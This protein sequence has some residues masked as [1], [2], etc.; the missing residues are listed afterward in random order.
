[1]IKKAKA[2][3]KY[4]VATGIICYFLVAVSVS[5]LTNGTC[6][7]GDSVY[8]YLFSHY[9][10][11]HPHNF[12]DHWAKPFFVLLSSPFAQF[13]FTGIKLFNCS[14]AAVSLW[15]C[16]KAAKALGYKNAWLAPVFLGFAPGWF[17]HLFSGLTEPLFGLLLITGVYLA[18][19]K[20]DVWA[21]IVISF[22]PFVRSEGLIIMVVFAFYFLVN[23]QY[24]YILWLLTGHVIYSVA[25]AFYYSDILWV[26]TRI[27]YSES[28]G[29][30]GSGNWLHF[31]VQLIYIIGIPLYVLLGV[32]FVKKI[33]GLRDIK[34]WNIYFTNAETLLVY[35]L[36]LGFITAHSIFW[37]WG[38]FESM[39]LKRVLVAIVPI[40]ALIAASG[41][42][43]LLELLQS[44]K[45]MC[46]IVGIVVGGYVIAFPFTANPAAIDWKRDLSLTPDEVAVVEATTYIQSNFSNTIYLYYSHPYINITMKRDPFSND[47]NANLEALTGSKIPH[48]FVVIWD[49]KFSVLENGVSLEQLKSNPQLE[50]IQEYY[51]NNGRQ[52]ATLAVFKSIE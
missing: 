29:K 37:F 33:T 10:F 1:M 15:Y 42:N 18:I 23:K 31:V 49:S 34:K 21:A 6:D 45:V 12:L 7:S 5:L 52:E 35:G 20:K 30:Y 16:Y 9:A 50:L 27:P 46:M 11:A 3:E 43:Y 22:L 48:P 40:A 14:V 4:W 51:Q 25:G 39:G 38:L 44:K 19:N 36:L 13:G 28:S 32:G 41:F 8:H 26:F 24:L 2:K 17:V 47:R